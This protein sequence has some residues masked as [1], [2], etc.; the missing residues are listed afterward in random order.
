ML[1]ILYYK[2]HWNILMIMSMQQRKKIS[3]GRSY[4]KG[5]IWVQKKKI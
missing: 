3:R 5:K 4:N 2:D 1:L